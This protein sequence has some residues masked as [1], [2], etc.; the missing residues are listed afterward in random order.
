MDI[1]TE[2]CGC[3]VTTFETGNRLYHPC[4]PCGFFQSGQELQM[5]AIKSRGFFSRIFRRKQ[6]ADNMQRSAMALAAVATT[7]QQ[8]HQKHVQQQQ[9]VQAIQKAQSDTRDMDNDIL[10]G[11]GSDRRDD[12]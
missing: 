12:N 4:P 10:P 7:L 6:I 2:P 1:K 8:E 5:A 3:K 9:L 11:P